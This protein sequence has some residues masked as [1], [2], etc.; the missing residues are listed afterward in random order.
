[1]EEALL[2][3]TAAAQ[4]PGFVQQDA[5]GRQDSSV[6]GRELTQLARTQAQLSALWRKNLII[7]RRRVA[8][9]LFYVLVPSLV[10]TA[11]CAIDHSTSPVSLVDGQLAPLKVRKC[12][13]FDFND[14]PTQSPCKVALFAP[15]NADTVAIMRSFA[16]ANGLEYGTDVSPASS[17]AD[18]AAQIATSPGSVDAGV[19]FTSSHWGP[20]PE[21]TARSLEYEMWV[22]TTNEMGHWNYG[23]DIHLLQSSSVQG[24][25]AALQI[26]LDAAILGHIAGVHT[27]LSLDVGRFAQQHDPGTQ[28]SSSIW[29]AY[30]D[31][32]VS[33][34]CS[35]SA[36]LV[37]QNIAGEKEARLLAALRTV[38]LREWLHWTSWGL[39]YVA[40]CLSSSLLC[41]VLGNMLQLR[42]YTQA[43]FVVHLLTMLLFL[44]SFAALAAFLGSCISKTRYVVLSSMLMLFVVVA[45][46]IGLKSAAAA[47][48]PYRY[49]SESGWFGWI[50]LG[51]MPWFH[52][53]RVFTAI[54]TTTYQQN[55]ALPD[56]FSFSDL[57]NATA[58]T[59]TNSRNQPEHFKEYETGTSLVAQL[60]L[61]FLYNIL[62]WYFGQ[63]SSTDEG[64]TQPAWFCLL[65]SYWG[66]G[67]TKALTLD[68]EDIIGSEQS[69]SRL[70]QSVRCYKLSKAYNQEMALR[71]FTMEIPS[72]TCVALLGQNVSSVCCLTPTA[73]AF[74]PCSFAEP[75]PRSS[76][77]CDTQ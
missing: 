29:T 43:S 51:M 27:E 26:A 50:A 17:P 48:F 66:K 33:L 71:E 58:Y 11:L 65:P 56:Y 63:V 1:M 52:Y 74:R 31:L 15:D 49:G 12:V 6:V 60:G 30:G 53:S 38:G 77:A 37:L 75:S 35:M 64:S 23:E 7:L 73:M 70:E 68:S 32:F 28:L 46:A 39:C 62:A 25:H 18:V 19:I 41:T 24:H 34:G 16:S 45:V 61:I 47:G 4:S 20:M 72:S 57:F 67:K 5:G 21:G 22:N 36:I 59:S 14:H 13:Q 55:A 9:T 42:L 44:M 2:D 8:S 69:K 3:S 40:P 10:I 54:A 76:G